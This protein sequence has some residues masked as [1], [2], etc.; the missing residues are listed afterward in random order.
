MHIWHLIYE[1]IVP[2]AAGLPELTA[3]FLLNEALEPETLFDH[4]T[5]PNR[6]GLI[7]Q[8]A[9]TGNSAI[10]GLN[11]VSTLCVVASLSVATPSACACAEACLRWHGGSV[12][13]RTGWTHI[14][15][16]CAEASRPD[17]VNPMQ[18]ITNPAGG[19]ARSCTGTAS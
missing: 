19:T 9:G 11:F 15:T 4:C 18:T 10:S 16:F 17:T 1:L 3:Y 2:G 7:T 6:E 13:V 8:P 5:P 12:T 14:C